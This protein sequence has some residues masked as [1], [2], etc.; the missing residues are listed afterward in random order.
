[1]K[2]SSRRVVA[3][4]AGGL[5]LA[6]SAG[7]GGG[8]GGTRAGSGGNASGGSPATGGTGAG[9]TGGSGTGGAS[10]G[11]G[12]TTGGTTGTT[13]S[14]G[15]GGGAGGTGGGGVG[16]HSSGS[17][18]AAGAGPT[19]SGGGA[20]GGNGATGG[21][22]TGA[23][24]ATQ[25]EL[26]T[27]GPSAYW[28]TQAAVTVV[29]GGTADLTID[30]T[31]KLQRFDGFGGCFNE[32]GWDA[33]SVLPADQV[34]N[35]LKL[36]FDPHE[37]ASF[38]YGRLP[39]GASDYSM[40]T[41]TLDD[42]A[43]DYAMANFSIARDREK[44]IP[45]IKAALQIRPDIHLW[46]SPW[47]PPDWM[48]DSAGNMKSDAQTQTAY[49]LY[50]ARF[51]EEYA[52]EGLKIEAVHPQNE[53]GYASVKW[54]Q[55]LFINF[56]KTYLG[57]LFAQRSVPA[58]IWCGTMS[59]PAD[60]TIATTLA[61]DTEAMKYVKGFG[62]QW[63]LQTTVAALASKG[64]VWQTEHKCGNY[65]FAT[66][67]WDQSRYSASMPQNDHAYGEESWQLIRDWI[68][69]GVN[70]Y[71]AWNMVL[72]T[73]GK[74]LTG[75]PQNALLVVDRSAKK[76][77]VTPAYYVFRHF[78]QYV[79]PGATRI[80]ITGSTDALAFKNPDGS[81]ITQVYNKGTTAKTTTVAVGSAS[82]KFDVPA[83]GWATLKTAP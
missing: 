72:D 2:A 46:A 25:T 30:Q 67:Y 40:S 52:K 81:V 31:S 43:G 50:L 23:A 73:V 16:G 47:I 32:M 78:S 9:Q 63:N 33:L 44:L 62:L 8:S 26:V 61:A 13:G 5:I 4:F 79:A 77:I 74:S 83:H 54:T 15:K 37:G 80:K 70:A 53:P 71:S 41:Y 20:A 24:G 39:L 76:L 21:T 19:G 14:G 6:F 28:N 42:T 7:C 64:P 12:G 69:A 58:E 22:S 57:P 10:G 29:T 11:T 82:Y 36:L 49:A 51:V 45:Y 68:V 3:G 55:T 75:W 56:F 60:G 27:S 35:A 17:A 1:M 38:L 18:G 66:P 65:N 59:A 34:T 48:K